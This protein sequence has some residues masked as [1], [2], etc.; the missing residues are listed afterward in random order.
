[1]KLQ[2][3]SGI[4]K[5][6]TENRKIHKRVKLLIR[7]LNEYYPVFTP[8]K[9][10]DPLDELIYTILSQATNDR[11]SLEAFKRLK[12]RFKTWDELP[13]ADLR[14]IEKAIHIGGLAPT[15]SKR[16][17]NLVE[18]IAERNRA[19]ERLKKGSPYH[20]DFLSKMELDEARKWLLS[21]EGVG[22]KTAACV[23]LFSLHKPAFPIDTHV[24]RI[25]IRQGIIPENMPAEKAHGVM[26]ELVPPDDRYRFHINLI[27]YGREI[28]HANHA[29]CD[30][31]AIARTC[32]YK[33]CF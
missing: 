28:C 24:H 11:N 9:N 13:N 6:T 8:K 16:I 29:E 22:E 12:S 10:R 25:L 18:T 15:K 23:L 32:L 1:M 31:C 3:Q 4:L 33:F 19:A 2:N 7:K 30:K 27:Q 26:Y 20:L 21:L 17:K 5:I 14:E